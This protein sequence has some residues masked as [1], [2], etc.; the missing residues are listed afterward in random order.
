MSPII[1]LPTLVKPQTLERISDVIDNSNIDEFF[2]QPS[3]HELLVISE[4]RVHDII[5]DLHRRT[6]E[7]IER[8]SW[9]QGDAYEPKKQR[10]AVDNNPSESPTR[11]P[12]AQFVNDEVVS[13]PIS[14]LSSSSIEA[15]SNMTPASKLQAERERKRAQLCTETKTLEATASTQAN[16]LLSSDKPSF[17]SFLKRVAKTPPSP[18]RSVR[19]YAF[20]S[21]QVSPLMG[22]QTAVPLKAFVVLG[23]SDTS[24]ELH[25]VEASVPKY[26][27]SR[28]VPTSA[29]TITVTTA[30]SPR[31]SPETSAHPKL[32]H[33]STSRFDVPSSSQTQPRKPRPCSLSS[34]VLPSI[35]RSRPSSPPKRKP[36]PQ[37]SPL[38][39]PL[40]RHPAFTDIALMSE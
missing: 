18:P 5:E 12:K 15:H 34:P 28:P 13:S 30:S 27:T 31:T 6:T 21:P 19:G 10:Y 2:C 11:K 1:S 37:D 3:P 4:M 17:Q 39:I 16:P 14:F 24:S 7:E 20:P 26:V 25:A 40:R 36:L 8:W 38:L 35:T 23:F 33:A 32:D 22:E 9:A 29:A